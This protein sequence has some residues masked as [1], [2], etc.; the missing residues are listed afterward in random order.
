[1]LSSGSLR[2]PFGSPREIGVSP[3]EINGFIEAGVAIRLDAASETFTDEK[4]L[5]IWQRVRPLR[6][7]INTVSPLTLAAALF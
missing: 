3:A 7:L 1:M 5:K 6:S 2:F 4:A